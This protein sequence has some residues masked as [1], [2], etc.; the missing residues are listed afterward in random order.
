M[1]KIKRLWC[2][3]D[4]IHMESTEGRTY[5]LPLS[6]SPRLLNATAE[7]RDAYSIELDGTAVRWEAID[8][9]IF[10]TAFY[11]SSDGTQNRIANL[12]FKYPMLS[13]S[14][15]A[16]AIGINKTLLYQYVYGIKA[17]GTSREREILNAFR[18]LGHELSQI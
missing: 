5:R 17:P 8:E 3:D 11:D 9:D 2:D 1:E 13:V 6:G 18:Q 16:K 12:F 14:G 4:F 15:M 10:I 7:E